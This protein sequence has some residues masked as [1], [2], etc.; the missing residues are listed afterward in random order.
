[1]LVLL[2]TLAEMTGQSVEEILEAAMKAD[3][4]IEEIETPFGTLR[5]LCHPLLED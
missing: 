4:P 3:L 2:E 1:M 5:V